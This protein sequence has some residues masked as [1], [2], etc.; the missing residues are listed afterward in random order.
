LAGGTLGGGALL[1]SMAAH[2]ARFLAYAVLLVLLARLW[3]PET[4]GLFAWHNAAASILGLAAG[5]GLSLKVTR[6]AALA[7]GRSADALRSALAAQTC[8]APLI[9]VIACGLWLAGLPVALEL[10]L[11]LAGAFICL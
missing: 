1:L 6:D 7:P 8:L 11:P 10:V 4:F 2:G 9:A 5:W 3:P